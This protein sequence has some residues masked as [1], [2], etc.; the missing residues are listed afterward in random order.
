MAIVNRGRAF[1]RNQNSRRRS[2]ALRFHHA[3]K[4][5]PIPPASSTAI[6]TIIGISWPAQL[7]CS[8]PCSAQKYARVISSRPWPAG[9]LK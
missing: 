4:G 9:S 6:T 7:M 2:G 8:R 3:R 1:A 5:N